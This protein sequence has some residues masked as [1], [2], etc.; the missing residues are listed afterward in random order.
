MQS[1]SDREP[2]STLAP[3]LFVPDRDERRFDLLCHVFANAVAG[4]VLAIE[5]DSQMVHLLPTAS[6]RIEMVNRAAAESRHAI[7][8]SRLARDLALQMP[9]RLVEPLWLAIR[10]QFSA[11]IAR[12]DLAACLIIQD[13]IAESMTIPLYERLALSDDLDA[14]AA[15][16]AEN[17][18][19]E[20]HE[21]LEI[22]IWRLR[23]L[24]S[25]DSEA[26]SD[27]LRW[28]HHRVM[29]ALSAPVAAPAGLAGEIEALW[30]RRAECYGA[31]LQGLFDSAVVRPLL[32]GLAAMGRL[33]GPVVAD[34]ACCTAP[35]EARAC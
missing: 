14:R 4:E 8:L 1:R 15:G 9:R 5:N 18:L 31:T 25:E 32:A 28:A 21:N 22:G 29:P 6:A 27:A 2:V 16:V 7:L 23:T 10:R 12:E 33:A 35:G 20:V 11:A 30:A 24:L 3:G 26:V 13:V 34:A 17:I 19:C